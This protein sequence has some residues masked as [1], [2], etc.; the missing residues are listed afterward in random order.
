MSCLIF[1]LSYCGPHLIC[2]KSPSIK[3]KYT[4][5]ILYAHHSDCM[6]SKWIPSIDLLTVTFYNRE[7]YMQILYT[8]TANGNH[9]DAFNARHPNGSQIDRQHCQGPLIYIY[10]YKRKEVTRLKFFLHHYGPHLHP[11]LRGAI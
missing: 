9:L 7:E 6:P 2:L 11:D 3:E 4:W 1:S 10:P 8:L 5:Q